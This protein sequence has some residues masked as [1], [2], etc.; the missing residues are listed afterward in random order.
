MKHLKTLQCIGD[1]ARSGSIRKSAERLAITPSALTRK[2]Q[3]FEQELGTTIFER[4]P[5]GMRLNPAG[6]LV[7]RTM[8][9]GRLD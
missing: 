5:Q 2:I 6:E 9:F 8:W 1:I 7:L 3:E 4:L